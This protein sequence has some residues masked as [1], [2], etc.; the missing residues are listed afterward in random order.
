MHCSALLIAQKIVI[1][2]LVTFL[3]LRKVI[4]FLCIVVRDLDIV[5]SR[6]H[7]SSGCEVVYELIT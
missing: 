4:I 1:G 5:T 2:M 7:F 6:V 3:T